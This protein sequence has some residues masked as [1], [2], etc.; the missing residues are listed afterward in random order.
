MSDKLDRRQFVAG[1]AAGIAL[2]GTLLACE[3]SAATPAEPTPPAPVAEPPKEAAPPA[4]PKEEA[5]AEEPK[6]AEPVQE[7]AFPMNERGKL[8]QVTH[9]GATTN[10]TKTNDEVVTKMV[11]EALVKFTG[12]GDAVK[13]I[14]RFLKKDD[15]VGIKVNTLGSPFSTVTPATAYAL[16]N[17]CHQFGIPKSNVYIYDQYGSRMRKAKFRPL[18]A[19]AK[20]PKDDFPVHNH[21]T[22]GY[23]AEKT[24]HGGK[25]KHNGKARGSQFPKLLA[26]L[27]A[28]INVCVPKDHDLTGVTGALKNVAY[29]NIERVPIFHCK[30]ECN[31]VCVHD[32][33]CNV[34]QIYK[35]EQ[36]G[37]KVRFIV[38]DAVRVLYQGG[39][40]DNSNRAA[41]NSILV[42]T[43]PVA[44]DTA[45]L[46][47]V[48]EHRVKKGLKPV[49]QDRGG[50]RAP[51]FIESAAKLGLGEMDMAKIKW[52]KH[53]MG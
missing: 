32:G 14:G 29:G 52:D 20:D 42:G 39:P 16:A 18:R 34:S 24:E 53:S 22:L 33:I 25:N 27:T 4:Q 50:R 28:V 45:I 21:E 43:D 1:A 26:K 17:L 49:E 3:D 10:I 8:T 40:Q 13:A 30:P 11:S 19:G 48:N 38:C 7:K 9:P 37:G 36:L 2:G 41:H 15:V 5:K 51:R 35:H 6:K 44:M 46:T 12:E 47:M 23:E 31:P